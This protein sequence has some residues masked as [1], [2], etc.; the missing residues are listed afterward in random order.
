[1]NLATQIKKLEIMDK[2]DILLD[3]DGIQLTRADLHSPYYT[4]MVD[5]ASK[6][7]RKMKGSKVS[8][9]PAVPMPVCDEKYD[10]FLIPLEVSW[11]PIKGSLKETLYYIHSHLTPQN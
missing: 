7:Y 10:Q 5:W 6:G 1:M 11:V 2:R 9:R 3:M 4:S 8:Y